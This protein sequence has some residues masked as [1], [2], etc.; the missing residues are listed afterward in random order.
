MRETSL[1][2][3]KGRHVLSPEHDVN[4]VSICSI[5][6]VRKVRSDQAQSSSST[7]ARQSTF[8]A[9]SGSG[10]SEAQGVSTQSGSAATRSQSQ[11][12]IPSKGTKAESGGLS[13]VIFDYTGEYPSFVLQTKKSVS[14]DQ[15]VKAIRQIRSED[16]RE[17]KFTHVNGYMTGKLLQYDAD[18][19]GEVMWTSD[20]AGSG[21]KFKNI[22][23]TAENESITIGV[24]I[25]WNVDSPQGAE[26]ASRV[27]QVINLEDTDDE[28]EK[29]EK[30]TIQV[31]EYRDEQ[32]AGVKEEFD[33]LKDMVSK[34]EASRETRGERATL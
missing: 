17:K 22:R 24:R 27:R 8:G 30:V 1:V 14:A 5:C 2:I 10:S 28:E 25:D 23:Q 3:A 6:D 9:M 4:S 19:V 13:A 34:Y 18:G 7:I 33:I 32:A 31:M 15:I 16:E 12:K 29:K 20:T 21:Q 26:G 11:N